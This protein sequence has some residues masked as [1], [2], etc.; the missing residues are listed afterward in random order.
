MGV[1]FVMS[2]TSKIKSLLKENELS[3]DNA[4]FIK[5]ESESKNNLN[6]LESLVG[7]PKVKDEKKLK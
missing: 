7:N 6:Y 4:V 3:F 1:Y 2:F 5:K